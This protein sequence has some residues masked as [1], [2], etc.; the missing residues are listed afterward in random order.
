LSTYNSKLIL[1]NTKKS[2]HGSSISS[3]V[4]INTMTRLIFEWLFF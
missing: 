1:P 3:R 4:C 2:G